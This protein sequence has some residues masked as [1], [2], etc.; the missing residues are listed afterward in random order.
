M[1]K[2]RKGK[3]GERGFWIKL[4]GR[5]E[6]AFFRQRM[7]RKMYGKEAMKEEKS[8][9]GKLQKLMPIIYVKG[10]CFET[11]LY[12]Q[13]PGNKRDSDKDRV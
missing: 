1:K 4:A 3:S 7:L 9:K 2:G 6:C 13:V 11:P 5:K 8:K 10:S 12:D